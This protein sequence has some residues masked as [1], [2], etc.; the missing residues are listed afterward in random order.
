MSS[1][2]FDMLDQSLLEREKGSEAKRGTM[3][4]D[5]LDIAT[6][7]SKLKEEKTKRTTKRT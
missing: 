5:R 4:Y 6:D 7:T 2:L 1:L 3:G